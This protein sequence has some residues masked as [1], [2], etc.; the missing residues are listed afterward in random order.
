MNPCGMTA[1]Q[2]ASRRNHQTRLES[3]RHTFKGKTTS[4]V[5]FTGRMNAQQTWA[6]LFVCG[7]LAW[8]DVMPSIDRTAGLI[9]QSDAVW[10]RATTDLLSHTHTRSYITDT[11]L[12]HPT[13][14]CGY[15]W[16][17]RKVQEHIIFMC[18]C[19]CEGVSVFSNICNSTHESQSFWGQM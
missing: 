7:R 13:G 9:T 6:S 4:A 5:L 17:K 1:C 12:E 2:C 10:R 15:V 3:K 14:G 8:D 16:P 18:L 11:T 19:V